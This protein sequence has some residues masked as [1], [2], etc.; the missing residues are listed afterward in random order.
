MGRTTSRNPLGSGRGWYLDRV[1]PG[2]DY[3]GER[4]VTNPIV[5]DDRVIFSTLIPNNDVCGFGGSSWV[6][7]L[8]LLTGKMMQQAQTDN[9]GD[10]LITDPRP[11]GDDNADPNAPRPDENAAGFSR[12]LEGG[13]NPGANGG[14]CITDGC[15]ADVLFGANSNGEIDQRAMRSVLGARGRQSW[16]QIR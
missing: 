15:L 14:R 12:G 9:N 4:V 13:I 2:D 11:D 7:I 16:R 1:S 6:M 5:R 8:D 10:G 3:Q